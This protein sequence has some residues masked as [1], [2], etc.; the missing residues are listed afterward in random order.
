MSEDTLDVEGESE[1]GH[2]CEA[3]G[4]RYYGRAAA[5][6]CCP[7]GTLLEMAAE[8]GLPALRCE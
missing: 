3:C 8:R 2:E 6:G 4:A 5:D 7:F 1:P